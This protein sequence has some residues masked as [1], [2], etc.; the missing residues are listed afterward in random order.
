MPLIAMM[1]VAG[2]TP[3]QPIGDPRSWITSDDYPA[4][5]L[6]ATADGLVRVVLAIDPSGSVAGCTIELSS[7]NAE[8]DTST[9]TALRKRAKFA[10]ARDESGVAVSSMRVQ[11]VRW[12]I[13]RDQLI[14]QGFRMTYSLDPTGHI[15]ACKIDEFGGHDSDLTCSPQMVEELAA[16]YL[17]KPLDRYASVAILLAMEVDNASEINILR[18]TTGERKIIGQARIRVSS[19]GVITECAESQVTQYNGRS[20]NLCSG[21][22]RVGQKEYASDPDGKERTLIVGFELTGQPR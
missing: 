3:A 15:S 13:P 12:A 8:L 18:S 10:P 11:S 20:L 16:A 1:V 22:V 5:A 2:I 14:S 7:G 21:P 19:A 4:S 6:A 9:C 17:T